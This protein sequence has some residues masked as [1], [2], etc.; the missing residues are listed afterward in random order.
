MDLA[1][2]K[3]EPPVDKFVVTSNNKLVTIAKYPLGV[4]P[5]I[6][7]KAS[8]LSADNF[9]KD[10]QP[11]HLGRH[12]SPRYSPVILVSGCPGLTAVS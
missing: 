11:R 1:K 6:R 7:L 10:R 4:E 5:A 8:K 2:L 12:L 9:K 3:N